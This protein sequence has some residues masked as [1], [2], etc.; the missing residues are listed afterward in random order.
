ME[1][2][3]LNHDFSD[4]DAKVLKRRRKLAA[5]NCC[6]N[7]R[8]VYEQATEMLHDEVDLKVDSRLKHLYEVV[9]PVFS[10]LTVLAPR[11][12]VFIIFHIKSFYSRQHFDTEK[13]SES[14]TKFPM[15]CV[16]AI[17]DLKISKY[18]ALQQFEYED[19]VVKSPAV[20]IGNNVLLGNDVN[21]KGLVDFNYS[22]SNE[23]RKHAKI[24]KLIEYPSKTEEAG[25]SMMLV[26]TM[27]N[28]EADGGNVA[29][30]QI[31]S[32]PFEMN[33]IACSVIIEDSYEA[34]NPM[35]IN[36]CKEMLPELREGL[37]CVHYSDSA[38]KGFA[39]ICND[40]LVGLNDPKKII[41]PDG[42]VTYIDIYKYRKWL[43]QCIEEERLILR[44][45]TGFP[46]K[47]NPKKALGETPLRKR[48]R[49]SSGK[50]KLMA[51]TTF[52]F[53]WLY[54]KG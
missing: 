40:E 27:H 51:I 43:K 39:L 14:L 10:A 44:I 47:A 7:C 9:N 18:C 20:I 34:V 46:N 17:W 3:T 31:A 1:F 29:V 48:V 41:V 28:L 19:D 11:L 38:I 8:S 50:P 42:P 52:I 33:A 13:L 32:K 23:V 6:D 30:I 25:I 22:T 12:A 37:L 53:F 5:I 21:I 15:F 4:F 26:V 35:Q 49:S 2:K 24:K 36:E 54:I 16:K 45:I